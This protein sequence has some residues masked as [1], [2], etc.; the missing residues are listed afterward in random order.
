MLQK[1]T[2]LLPNQAHDIKNH[3]PQNIS[4]CP[5]FVDTFSY[6]HSDL[7]IYPGNTMY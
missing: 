6:A 1:K 7:P 5:K 3:L 2:A 4:T